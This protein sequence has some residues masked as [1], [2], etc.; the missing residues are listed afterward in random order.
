MRHGL[1]LW[2]AG[3]LLFSESELCG[4]RDLKW[5]SADET[6]RLSVVNFWGVAVMP[7]ECSNST[8]TWMADSLA[9]DGPQEFR[10]SSFA[11]HESHPF[12][13]HNAGWVFAI[14]RLSLHW[15]FKRRVIFFVHF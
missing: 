12:S 8:C 9:Q 5:F 15:R 14:S 11:H 2:R 10:T 1:F 7:S 6:V 4:Q 3:L 13:D